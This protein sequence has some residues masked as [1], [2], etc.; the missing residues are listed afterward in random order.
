MFLLCKVLDLFFARKM[1]FKAA[2]IKGFN[3]LAL[4][5]LLILLPFISLN[6]RGLWSSR[7]NQLKLWHLQNVYHV[8]IEAAVL[9]VLRC[10]AKDLYHLTIYQSPCEEKLL[11]YTPQDRS[12][13]LLFYCCQRQQITTFF[14]YSHEQNTDADYIRK[15][16]PLCYALHSPALS[17]AFL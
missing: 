13:P 6:I 7:M 10:K 2:G 15:S 8:R 9:H 16:T 14:W 5:C 3:F 4:C 1:L 12:S 17:S 11:R